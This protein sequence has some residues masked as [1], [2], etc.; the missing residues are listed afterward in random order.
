MAFKKL[1]LWYDEDLLISLG[2]KIKAHD[3]NF[4]SYKFVS[5][6]LA[7]L[8]PL[9]FKD[10]V[11]LIGDHIFKFTSGE[12]PEKA[13]ILTKSLGPEN[14]DSLGTF[15]NYF[16]VWPI[17][18]VAEHY[19]TDHFDLSINFIKEITKRSTGEFA[20][21]PFLEKEPEKILNQMSKWSKDKN[22]HVRRLSSEGLRP[23]LP[24]ARKFD[25]FKNDPAPIFK[26]LETLNNDPIK[27]VQKSVANHLNDYLKLN[28]KFAKAQI[29]TWS[30][31]ESKITRWIVF[32]AI[33]NERKADTDWSKRILQ[34]IDRAG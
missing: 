2:N 11:K 14:P 23:M 5:V 30:Q 1:K 27:Y 20:I 25:Y 19:G 17:A 13:A 4:E 10:R 16:W 22:F 9:E 3:K 18:I 24:W 8:E 32:H 28:P 12:Y 31:S 29:E 34:M 6:C 33:R 7:L 15:N 21:R 26:I